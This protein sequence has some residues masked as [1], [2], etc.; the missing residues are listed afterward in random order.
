LVDGRA[1]LLGG[2][3]AGVVDLVAQIHRVRR[4]SARCQ[5]PLEP[6]SLAGEQRSCLGLVHPASSDPCQSFILRELG[7]RCQRHRWRGWSR[8]VVGAGELLSAALLVIP[9]RPP[10][11]AG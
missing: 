7:D 4:L 6:G 2:A 9:R 5:Q 3:S 8:F 1:G 11:L 10:P